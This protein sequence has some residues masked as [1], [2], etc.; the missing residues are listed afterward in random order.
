[1]RLLDTVHT[2]L[3]RKGFLVHSVG[4]EATVYQS[5]EALANNNIGAVLVMSG[6]E[7][8]G[9]FS[10]RDYARKVVLKGKWSREIRVS[11]I[12]ISPVITVT[13]D[14]RVEECMKIMTQNRIRH[15]PVL[16][17]NKVIGVVSIGDLVNC[18]ISAQEETIHHLEGYIAGKY[19]G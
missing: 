1:M 14:H 7:V 5:L 9:I 10:E 3:E 16:D 19:P 13:P 18:I 8:V 17:D 11:E 12:M 2:I 15:L 6:E 4:P